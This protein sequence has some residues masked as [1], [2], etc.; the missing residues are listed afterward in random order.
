M[1]IGQKEIMARIASQSSKFCGPIIS[2]S[3]ARRMIAGVKQ[4]TAV[5]RALNG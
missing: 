2:L 5:S 4:A 1:K 3:E